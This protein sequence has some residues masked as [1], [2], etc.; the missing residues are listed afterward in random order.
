[1]FYCD[2]AGFHFPTGELRSKELQNYGAEWYIVI[3]SAV[4]AFIIRILISCIF[5]KFKSR[6]SRLNGEILKGQ[7]DKTYQELDLTKVNTEDNYQSLTGGARVAT[8]NVIVSEDNSTYTKLSE[9]RDVEDNYQTLTW[10]W[11]INSV[12]TVLI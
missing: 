11:K 5:C 10:T 3:V 7:V 1:M 6:R 9:T 8:R 12:S 2:H 4:S